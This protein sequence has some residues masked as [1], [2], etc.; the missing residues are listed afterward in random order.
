MIRAI[1]ERL[2]KFKFF[3][4][5]TTLL[6]ILVAEIVLTCLIPAWRKEFFNILEAKQEHLFAGSLTFFMFLMLSLGAATGLKVWVGQ[7]VSFAVREVGARLLL[8]TWAKGPRVADNYTQAM[9]DSLRAATELYLTIG[10]EVIISLAI[11]ITL[12]A[13][14]MHNTVIIVSSI[15]YTIIVSVVAALFNKPLINTDL[16][17]QSSSGKY[18]EALGDIANGNGDFSS[19]AKFK[20]FVID[21]Y[22]YIRTVMYFVL[23]S[24]VK[25]SLAVLVPY[26]LLSTAY[27]NG[28]LS[29]GDFMAGVATFELI[30]VNSTILLQM[31]PQLTTAR[32]SWA[33]V[34]KFYK[35]II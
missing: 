11:V 5:V 18:R 13:S 19:K 2:N 28:T 29:L 7:L 21:Y 25:G 26:L 30:V 4:L 22:N 31:Y 1:W 12:M 32:A 15:I 23:F 20:V 34:I 35:E 6:V 16:K 10:V 17:L 3:T 8:K 9:T 33:L 14:N 27:F 24:R